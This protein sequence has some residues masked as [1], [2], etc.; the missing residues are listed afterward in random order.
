MKVMMSL[1]SCLLLIGCGANTTKQLNTVEDHLKDIGLELPLVINEQ[2][3]L[4]YADY[5]YKYDLSLFELVDDAV[6]TWLDEMNEY[7]RYIEKASDA[8]GYLM[9]ETNDTGI[10]NGEIEIVPEDYV[11]IPN[12]TLVFLPR[13]NHH[14]QLTAHTSQ[15]ILADAPTINPT[16]K[17]NGLHQFVEYSTKDY[18]AFFP[19]LDLLFSDYT[20]AFSTQAIAYSNLYDTLDHTSVEDQRILKQHYVQL[21]TDYTAILT[22]FFNEVYPILEQQLVQ[23]GY[24]HHPLIM[25]KREEIEQN[26]FNYIQIS[27]RYVVQSSSFYEA[28]LAYCDLLSVIQEFHYLVPL[29]DATGVFELALQKEQSPLSES[30]LSKRNLDIQLKLETIKQAN[31]MVDQYFLDK[32]V[33]ANEYMINY[34]TAY[35]PTSLESEQDIKTCYYQLYG[36]INSLIRDL[37]DDSLF[38]LS[39]I[40]SQHQQ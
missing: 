7:L 35:L 22:C 27:E 9:T 23:V 13:D 29:T 18:V 3:V 40:L 31:L 20:T 28:I 19:Q 2:Y 39:E 37:K 12:S 21:K 10:Q 6:L 1:I 26:L 17:L 11:P 16:K 30:D 25:P 8:M 36:L 4:T 34:Y 38:N 33:V 5:E 32:L 15:N 14:V 24:P